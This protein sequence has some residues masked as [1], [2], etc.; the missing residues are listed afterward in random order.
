MSRAKDKLFIFGNSHVLSRI[1]MKK[2]GMAERKYFKDIIEYIR[3]NGQ[4]I[5][6]DGG[7]IDEP[8]TSKRTIKLA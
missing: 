1:E 3:I 2:T 8:I 7:I 6:Y 5:K 4:Y